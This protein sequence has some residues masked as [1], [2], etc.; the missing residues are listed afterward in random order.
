LGID[1][2][3]AVKSSSGFGQDAIES[4]RETSRIGI[5]PLD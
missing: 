1:G 2:D 5:H 3:C 4:G